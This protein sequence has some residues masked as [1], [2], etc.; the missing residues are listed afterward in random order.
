[1]TEYDMKDFPFE[2]RGSGAE[3]VFRLAP[4]LVHAIGN[5][6]GGRVRLTPITMA[7]STGTFSF[8]S[9]QYPQEL[10][11]AMA[12]CMSADS[13]IACDDGEMLQLRYI[14]KAEIEGPR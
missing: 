9:C 12:M 10:L 4:S 13:W 11:E 2:L 1:M 7:T 6:E 3:A 5:R 14:V 8:V